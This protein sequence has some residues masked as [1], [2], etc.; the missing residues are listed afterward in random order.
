MDP[1]R[2]ERQLVT[3]LVL[4]GGRGS[5]MGGLDKGLQLLDGQ[6][7]VW[8]ALERLRPQV[9]ALAINAN[10]H[11]DAYAAFGVPVWPDA[12]AD[13][14]GPLAGMLAGL[15]ALEGS[16]TEW[17]V[18][19]PCDTPRFPVDLVARL[20]AAA[21]EAGARAAMPVTTEGE[22]AGAAGPAKPQP[23]QPQPVF[24]LL[25]RSLRPALEAALAGGERKIERFTRGQG[26]VL[27]PFDDADAFFNANTLEELERLRGMAPRRPSG[28]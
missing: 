3:G 8:H 16:Q 26:Q 10:R 4:A 9:G 6:P 11:H 25:H 13:F 2:P 7:L 17:L 24:C 28:D 23:P 27:V 19:V 21:R 1:S 15:A 18:T 5:R 14:P 22:A 12:L 20:F